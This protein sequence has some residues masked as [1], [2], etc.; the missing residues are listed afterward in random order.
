MQNNNLKYFGAALLAMFFW[1]FSFVW[2]KVAYRAYDP[3]TVVL[4][5]LSLATAIMFVIAKIIGK[6][7]SIQSGDLKWMFLLSFFEPFLYFMG[8]SFGLKYVSP[9]V[10]AVI[11]ATIPLF[12]PL[13]AWYFH[14]E[15]MSWAN[16]VGL[17]ISFVGVSLVVLDNSFKF[18]ASPLG[19][20]LEFLAVLS[21]IG[22]AIILKKLTHNYNGYTIISYQNLF[23]AFMFLPFWA[24]FEANKTF[25]T[26]FNQEAFMAIVKLAIFASILGFIF[27][28][29][30]IR[31][32][33]INKSNMFINVMPVFVV[34]FS[35]FILGE[36]IN[37]QKVVG[38][39]IV[40]SG[41]FLAQLKRKKLRATK[42]VEI[43][44]IE[45]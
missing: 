41:L 1:S 19:V 4:I 37:A 22:Y 44:N 25:Q 38:I 3:M 17:S 13:A 27:F 6:L 35:F 23:G 15:K 26:P 11:V 43:S 7:Q 31:H 24:I 36:E 14:K 10:A 33:G 40:I 29:Y 28:T 32:L 39:V 42:P 9:T 21:T 12:T 45:I 5:R 18:S 20:T 34:I 8:E 30:S 2:F 16:F